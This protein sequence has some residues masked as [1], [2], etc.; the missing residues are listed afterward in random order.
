MNSIKNYFSSPLKVDVKSV[1]TENLIKVTKMK[2]VQ[3]TDDVGM[4]AVENGIE[5]SEESA[6]DRNKK[7][8][9]NMESV[10]KSISK[11]EK[12]R[13]KKKN[14]KRGQSKTPEEG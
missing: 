12:Y 10:L 11:S 13:R 14:A 3:E 7:I 6:E 2:I 5:E 1:N 8:F 9:F 4:A